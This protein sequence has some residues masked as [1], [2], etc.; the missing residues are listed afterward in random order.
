[1][2]P[3]DGSGSDQ[4]AMSLSDMNNCRHAIDLPT[5]GSVAGFSVELADSIIS[6][7]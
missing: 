7:N 2:N 4:P 3:I 6:P 1:V 5:F